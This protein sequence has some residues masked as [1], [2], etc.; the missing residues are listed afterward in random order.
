MTTGMLQ[1]LVYLAG[2]RVGSRA[3]VVGAEHVSFSALLT[4]EHGGA[5]TVAMTTELPRH[6]SFA[7]FRA[8]AAARFRVPL[9]TGTAVTA[10][11]GGARVEAVELTEVATGRVRRIDCDTVVFTADWIPDHEL[12]V[13]AGAELDPGT[14]G[15]VVDSRLRTTRPGLFACGNLLHGAETADVAALSGRH[16]AAGVLD[17]LGGGAWPERIRHLLRG[18]AAVDQPER[19]QRGRGSGFDPAL[20]GATCCGRGRRFAGP[21]SSSPRTAGC[22]RAGASRASCRGARQRSGPVG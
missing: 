8:G 18:A 6:Q 17:R 4:L 12:A 11:H 19:D 2:E 15:P 20:E 9:L 1:Q 10:I 22:S 21:G 5:R 13:L 7:L 14:R 16:V 3:V